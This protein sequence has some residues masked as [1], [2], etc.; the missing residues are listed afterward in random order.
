MSELLSILLAAIVAS[1][2]GLHHAAADNTKTEQS[3]EKLGPSNT[4]L[5]FK[6]AENI[7]NSAYKASIID[8]KKKPSSEKR[9]CLDEAKAV[10][11]KSIVAAKQ[12]VIT[13]TASSAGQ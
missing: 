1:S 7:A 13:V 10:N 8:C 2:M 3:R 5:D 4:R 11:E 9:V 6:Q 12:R